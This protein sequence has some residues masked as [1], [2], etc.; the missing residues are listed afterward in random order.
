MADKPLVWLHAAVKTPPFS[1]D[2]RIEAGG[3]L[4]RLQR[5]EKLALP[6]SRPMPSI[7]PGCHELRVHDENLTWRIVYY[8]GREAIVILDVFAKK[9]RA[10]PK[11]VIDIARKR[12][13]MYID[14]AENR[15]L[16][17]EHRRRRSLW[18]RGFALAIRQISSVFRK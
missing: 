7:G 9:T 13:D 18:L 2:A 6:E 4:R 12:L 10:T 17:C 14:A 5:G 16:K 1:N 3:Y 8:L 11:R 15:G